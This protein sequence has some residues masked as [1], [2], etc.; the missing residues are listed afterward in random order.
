MSRQRA[1]LAFTM[2]LAGAAAAT[3][4]FTLLSWRTFTSNAVEVTMPLLFIGALVAAI[5]GGGRWLRL[6]LMVVLVAQIVVAGLC[7][8]GSATGS[9]AP[10][11]VTL[12]EFVRAFEDGLASSRA[13]MAPIPSNVPP[14]TALLVAGGALTFVVL[15]LLAAGIR[16]IPLAGLV[17]LTVYSVPV[18]ITGNGLSWWAFIAMSVG[19]LGMLHLVN[20]EQ[21][22]GWGRGMGSEDEA[23]P[24]AFGVR[25][26]AVRTSALAIGTTATTLALALPLIIPTL[27]VTL[28]DGNGPGQREIEVVNPMVDLRRDLDRGVDVPLLVVRT[29]GEAPSYFRTTVLTSFNGDTWTPGDRDIPESQVARGPMPDLA[30]IAV[31]TPRTEVPFDVRVT[32]DFESTWLPTTPQVSSME[33]EG[34]WRYDVSTMDFMTTDPET[35]TSEMT[36][37]FTGVAVEPDP[38]LM[39]NAVSGAADVRST[40]LEVSTEV[41]GEIR[42]LAATVTADATTRFRKAQALQQWFREDG[43]FVYSTKAIENAEDG[44]LDAFLDE[45]GRVGYCEQFAASMAIM[46]RI[47]G[48]P[49]RVAVGFLESRR[50]GPGTYEFSSHDLHAWPEL[51]FPGAG[52]VRFEPT[53]GARAEGVPAYTRVDLGPGASAAPS[54]SA[55]RSS[56][57]LAPRGE[58]A[59]PEEGAG[60]EASSVPWGTIVLAVLGLV[61]LVALVLVPGA[62]RRRRRDRRLLGGIEDLWLELRDHAIDLGHAWPAGLSPRATGVWLSTHFGPS[63]D[64]ADRGV[65]RPRQGPDQDPAAVEALHRLVGQIE[66]A[67]YARSVSALDS[68]QAVEDVR[69]VESAL[70]HGVGPRVRRRSQWLPR[71][72]RPAPSSTAPEVVTRQAEDAVRA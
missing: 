64:G 18:T 20:D 23:D 48:I 31:Q 27:E 53:P 60:D 1:S 14:I 22:S 37:S 69:A 13:Y 46:A 62:V 67:R 54:P 9:I 49:A 8:L 66:R 72:L 44:N 30:G 41:S 2:G 35:T 40:Y 51:Y 70:D 36:Y 4:W 29:P 3:T 7:V 32:E 45:S 10:T 58:T 5:G 43:N 17:L 65:E 34:D 19:F 59:A 12:S 68:A 71:S 42:R 6:P 52:W 24:S 63:A 57:E 28:F 11:P 15:D 50:V 21:I 16:R 39:D 33:A 55:T 47:L 56:A 38:A 26:G 25:T 61:L